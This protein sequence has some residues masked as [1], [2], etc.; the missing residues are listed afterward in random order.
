[1]VSGSVSPRRNTACIPAAWDVAEQIQKSIVNDDTKTERDS[2]LENIDHNSFHDLDNSESESQ[3]L[4][5]KE[6]DPTEHE[7]SKDIGILMQ[8]MILFL[9]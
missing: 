1:M 6:E 4:A 5:E 8:V 7:V 3:T 9:S 2:T